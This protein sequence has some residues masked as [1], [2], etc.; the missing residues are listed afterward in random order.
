MAQRNGGR[1]PADK[2]AKIVDGR[3]PVDGHGG[4]DMPVWGDA[5]KNPET[6]FDD[7]QVKLRIRSVVDH[8]ETLQEQ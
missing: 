4:P 7:E 1:Y 2:V 3:E 6:G 5:F 8:L